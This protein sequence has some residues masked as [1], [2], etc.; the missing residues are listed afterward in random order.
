MVGWWSE[1]TL[2][3][4]G[5]VV[6]RVLA[7]V[8]LRACVRARARACVCVCAVCGLRR[9]VIQMRGVPRDS[10]GARQLHGASGE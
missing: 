5:G 10:E 7:N 2:K 9:V 4:C 3:E 1:L 6:V 8:T